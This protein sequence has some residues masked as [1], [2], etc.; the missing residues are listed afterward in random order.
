LHVIHASLIAF[1]AGFDSAEGLTG[2]AQPATFDVLV[3]GATSGGIAAAVAASRRANVTVGL[4]VANGGGCGPSDAGANHIGGMTTGGLGKTDIGAAASTHLVGGVAG[5]FYS[6]VAAFY[7]RTA[8]PFYN[9]EPHVAMTAFE[10]LLNT[11]SITVLRGGHGANI[12]SAQLREHEVEP[13]VGASVR[14]YPHRAGKAAAH[15]ESI[16]LSDGRVITADVF[17]DA[18]YEGDLLAASGASWTVGRE[19]PAQYKEQE[20]GRR[21]DDSSNNGYEFKVRVDPFEDDGVTPLPLLAVRSADVGRP[22]DADAKVQAY[23]FRLCATSDKATQVPFPPP[24]PSS[25]FAA[26]NSTWE[27]GRR[28]FRDPNWQTLIARSGCPGTAFPCFAKESPPLNPRTGHKRDWN[29]PFLGPLNSDCV[30]GCNQS[31]YPTATLAG[32]LKIWEDHKQY[33]L[34]LLHFYRT[35]PGVPELVRN[36]SQAWG[37]CFDVALCKQMCAACVL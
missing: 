5:E 14:S 16:K 19:S 3:Y 4:V 34:S 10:R 37:Q 2:T 32:R 7:N 13:V 31:G 8:P 12:A 20:A 30:Q 23:N 33:Y 35:D 18:S 9:H 27:L 11:S 22:G 29:N 1:G 26:T 24:D 6:M 17:V 25:K 15:I 21:P 36:R 28:V